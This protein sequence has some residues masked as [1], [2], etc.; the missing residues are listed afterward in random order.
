MKIVVEWRVFMLRAKDVTGWI[1]DFLYDDEV[2]KQS[3][4]VDFD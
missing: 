4:L 3:S 1:L 2:Y